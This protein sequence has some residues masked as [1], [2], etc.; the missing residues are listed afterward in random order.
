MGG[1]RQKRQQ[2]KAAQ[3]AARERW[4]VI[5]AFWTGWIGLGYVFIDHHQPFWATVLFFAA[6]VQLI[7]GA[8]LRFRSRWFG[9]IF[10]VI[11]L[12]AFCWTDWKWVV[13]A[14]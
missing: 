11:A 1:S 12:A 9:V 5:L 4:L 13:P 8:W 2:T 3:K 14:P 7:V 10:A 6:T